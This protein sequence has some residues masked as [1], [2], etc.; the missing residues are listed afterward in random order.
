LYFKVDYNP[1]GTRLWRGRKPASFASTHSADSE[2][3][4]SRN[5]Y[6]NLKVVGLSMEFEFEF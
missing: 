6:V 2:I 3:Q 4:F 5:D 1:G